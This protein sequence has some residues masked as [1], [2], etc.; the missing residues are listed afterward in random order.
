MEASSNAERVVYSRP[1][2]LPLVELL[3]VDNCARRW[4]VFHETYTVCTGLSI[5]RLA[6]W[7]YRGHTHS[8]GAGGLML[9]EPGELHANTGVTSPASFRVLMIDPSVVERAAQ[10]LGISPARPHLQISQVYDPELFEE[11]AGLHASLEQS[12]TK[13]ERQSRFATSL[14]LLLERCTETSPRPLTTRSDSLA[15]RRAQ[16]FIHEHVTDPIRL[17]QLAEASGGVSR[18]HLLRAFTAEI[19]L[20]PHAY[21]IQV[22]MSAARTLL[23]AGLPTVYVAAELGFADQ[24]HFTRHFHRLVGVTPAA[25]AR[26]TGSRRPWRNASPHTL[27]EVAG[28]E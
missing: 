9:M 23:A 15:V 14:Q 8:Q 4:R 22:R 20:P 6:E 11:F 27:F 7:R 10:E 1:A 28:Q 18:F 3:Q 5:S 21:Q 26:A 17:D 13:L 19:G 12:S 2:D 25:Y 24:S 16:A